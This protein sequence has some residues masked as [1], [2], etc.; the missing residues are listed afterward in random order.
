MA[1][2]EEMYANVT[3]ADV[4]RTWQAFAR[5]PMIM[6][7]YERDYSEHILSFPRHIHPSAMPEFTEAGVEPSI[8]QVEPS[9]AQI[10]ALIAQVERSITQA[11]PSIA[12][13]EA[14][15][16]Q[17]EPPMAQVEPSNRSD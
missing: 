2:I 4:Y 1:T 16:A 9:I 14:L 5:R 15:I 11:E 3:F 6:S 10:E 12:Q 13:I 8:A 7:A 17:V